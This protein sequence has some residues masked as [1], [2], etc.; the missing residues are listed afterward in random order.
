MSLSSVRLGCEGG[1][2]E[3]E[4]GNDDSVDGVGDGDDNDDAA[5]MG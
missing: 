5:P 4:D 1:D 3:V 2:D